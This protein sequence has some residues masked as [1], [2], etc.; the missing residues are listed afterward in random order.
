MMSK[1]RMKEVTWN[2]IRMTLA[3]V[4]YSVGISLFLDPNEL[5]PGG[6]TGISI[7]LN[8]LTGVETGTLILLLNVPILLLGAWKFGIKVIISTL[9]CIVFV[10]L[11]TNM[12]APVGALTTEPILAILAGCSMIAIGM[13]FVFRAGGTT[14]GTDIIIKVIRRSKPHIR[15]GTLLLLLDAAVVILSVIVFGDLDKALYAGLGAFVT[16]LVLD[17]VLYGR[18]EA[19]MIYI[20]SDHA[21]KIAD[22]LLLE[23]RVGVTYVEGRGAFSGRA[24]DIILCVMRKPLFPK[25]E[26]IVKQEDSE[27]F[28]IISSATEIYGE[29]Y[30]SYF[31]EKL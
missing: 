6:V 16:S 31:G 10:S 20:I 30:K 1:K 9:Y 7:V 17:L 4:V 15:T 2:Y 25:A 14:G 23:L 26:E 8:R 11:L 24:K 22:R 27:A 3:A 28:M 29:G 19:K 13:G 18:D 12:L 5:A 21:G